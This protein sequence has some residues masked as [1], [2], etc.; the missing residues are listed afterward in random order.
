MTQI[1][2]FNYKQQTWRK[3]HIREFDV[4]TPLTLISW[5]TL[6]PCHNYSK[7]LSH[8]F[9]YA[10][11]T[12]STPAI[13]RKEKIILS[14]YHH[15]TLMYIHM[16]I[17]VCAHCIH[18]CVY[19]CMYNA[20]MVGWLAGHICPNLKTLICAHMLTCMSASLSICMSSCLDGCLTCCL[21]YVC[22]YVRQHLKH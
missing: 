20:W 11:T 16:F 15:C 4:T 3:T 8:C 7:N 5:G 17:C 2:I 10:V 21:L 19:V 6:N 12:F 22:M 13:L 14:H 9:L 1:E 18:V